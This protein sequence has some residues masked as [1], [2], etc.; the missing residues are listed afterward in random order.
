MEKKGEA[1]SALGRRGRTKKFLKTNDGAGM[2]TIPIKGTGVFTF[3]EK[4]KNYR[5]PPFITRWTGKTT[6]DVKNFK[7][8][9]GKTAG[10]WHLWPEWELSPAGRV[11]HCITGAIG[12][13]HE[14]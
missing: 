1:P 9:R 8:V 11:A 14:G 7:E 4:K 10:Y 2:S 5:G 6:D 12:R 3:G 13:G